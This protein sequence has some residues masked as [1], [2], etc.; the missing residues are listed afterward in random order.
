MTS[1]R[2]IDRLESSLAAR[3]KFFLWLHRA[4]AAGGFVLHWE[5]EL[6]GPMA[7][8][9]WFEDEEAYLLFRLVNDV[10]LTILKNADR[11]RDLRSFAHCAID[12]V[13]RQISR[14]D[15]EGALVPI[16]P[17]PKVAT[18]AA[19]FVCTKFRALLEEAEL[20]ASAIGVIS[21]AYFGGEDI[22]FADT[23][24]TSD[25]EMS[26]LSVT[27]EVCDTLADWLNLEPIKAYG[28]IP[29]H[30]MV[31]AKAKQ[32][33]KISRAEA[34]VS[35]RDLRKFKDALQRAF[36]EGG[37]R[38]LAMTTDLAANRHTYYPGCLSPGTRATNW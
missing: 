26:K 13:V 2:R 28:L 29:G 16:C 32:I 10:N 38:R 25:A 17:I 34:L 23:R 4:K 33:V 36:P 19:S 12:G 6:K 18:L 27:A 5:K 15:H 9:E 14:P 21:D 24:A 31:D 3:E 20:M 11:N 35:C 30:P 7:P 37:G 22:L 8:F 1:K